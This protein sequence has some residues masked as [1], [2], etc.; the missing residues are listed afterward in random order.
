VR[1]HEDFDQQDADRHRR[2]VRPAVTGPGS[3]QR[4]EAVAGGAP[5]AGPA[6]DA[7]S[8]NGAGGGAA[9]PD[10]PSAQAP[11]SL[12]RN[13]RFQLLWIGST[14]VTLG[15]EATDVAYPLLILAITGSSA[16]AGIFGFLQFTTMLV[17][18]LPIGAL[19]DRWDRRRVLLFAEGS[20]ALLIGSVAAALA[21]GHLTL[22]YLMVV[23]VLLGVTTSF[24]GPVRML[25]IRAVVPASQLTTA[26]TQ[27]EVREGASGLAGPPLGGFLFGIS[28]L[29]P[30]VVCAASFALSFACA[31]VVRIPP[32]EEAAED[33]GGQPD[34]PE[35]SLRGMFAGVTELLRSPLL[36]RA[37]VMISTFYLTAMGVVLVVIVL[38]RARGDRPGA[39]GVALA[40]T[41]LGTL[42]GSVLVRHL[43]RLMR[44]GW[45]LVM[46]S[47][48]V[49]VSIA[50]LAVPFGAWWVFCVLLVSALTVPA[51][52]VLIDILIFRQV[53]DERRGRT[54]MATMTAIGVGPPLGVLAAGLLLQYAGGTP[55]VLVFA[56][57]QAAATAFGLLDRRV[58]NAPWPPSG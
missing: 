47:G 11:A 5:G 58:R 52:R 15:V 17:L 34:E 32:R 57:L 49:S 14:S 29:L 13:W 53:P 55:T 35:G 46:V 6:G 24:G 30:F 54:I 40:G 8:G 26:L 16:R 51:M 44:P 7:A 39:I 10:Q 45:L 22:A 3:A 28:R 20:R 43:H 37:L 41:A 38:L 25:M 2:L 42:L 1:G 21:L 36:L 48:I 19:V 4:D 56:G 31:L 27:E 12:W 18:A 50:L 9:V 33:G 23:A